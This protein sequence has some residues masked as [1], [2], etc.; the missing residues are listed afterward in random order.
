MIRMV[1]LLKKHGDGGSP[2]WSDYLDYHDG[3]RDHDDKGDGNDENHDEDEVTKRHGPTFGM[4]WIPCVCHL[5][6][7]RLISHINN[8][9]EGDD[10][11]IGGGIY[12]KIVWKI[13]A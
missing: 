6:S 4:R 11:K 9:G 12:K 5:W 2:R 10:R 1:I 8:N 3:D 7:T 13:V